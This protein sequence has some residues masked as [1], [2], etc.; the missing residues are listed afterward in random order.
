MFPELE[1]Q[2][3]EFGSLKE[4]ITGHLPSLLDQFK[5]Y[6]PKETQPELYD[7]IRKPFSESRT[8]L[9]TNLEDAL[10]ELSSDQTLK[11][12]FSNS[13]LPEFWIAVADEY[14]ELSRV[15]I[16]VLPPFGS[17]FLCE[18][19]FPTVTYIKK[20]IPIMS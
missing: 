1:E 6:F 5:K 3:T 16:D 7:W 12:F 17:I 18:Q 4:Y 8:H 19:P 14:T 9:P 15:A 20:Q 11:T 13:T 10:L 2:W